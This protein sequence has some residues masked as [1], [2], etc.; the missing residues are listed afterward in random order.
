M[1]TICL[2]RIELAY[3]NIKELCLNSA[4]SFVSPTTITIV[5]SNAALAVAGI[6]VEASLQDLALLLLHR[7][8]FVRILLFR[9]G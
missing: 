4:E 7:G 2:A 3:L 9:N 5:S 8:V 6:V 1:R